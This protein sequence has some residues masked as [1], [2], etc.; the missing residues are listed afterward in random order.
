MI[1]NNPETA[2]FFWGETGHVPSI[3]DMDT[4][5][6]SQDFA[7]TVCPIRF[8]IGAIFFTRD[9]WERMGYFP[10]DKNNGMGTDEVALCSL[11]M[12]ISRAVIVSENTAVGHLSF[13]KQNEVMK[14]YFLAHPEKFQM[15]IE[16]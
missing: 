10:V 3:D 6:G 13:G 9:I 11:A 16:A 8:S 7:F 5:F 14:E 1:E 4:L 2:R 15:R 12:T